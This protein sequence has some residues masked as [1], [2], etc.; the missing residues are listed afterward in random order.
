MLSEVLLEWQRSGDYFSYQGHRVF[1]KREG[2]GD[3]LLLLHGFPS[4]SI[5]W[6]GIWPL[7][8]PNFDLIAPDMMGYGFSDKS[9]SFGYSIAKQADVIVHLVEQLK[10]P[11]VHILGHDYGDTV[12]QE[13][14]ARHIEGSLSFEIKSVSLLNGGLFPETHKPLLIQK[15][16]MSPIGSILAKLMSKKKFTDSLQRICSDGLTLSDIDELWTLL[17]YKQGRLVVPQLIYY[18]QER[19]EFRERWVG[20][21]QQSDAVAMPLHLIDGVIDPISGQ[22]LVNRFRKLVPGAKVTELEEIGHYPQ[23][24]APQKVVSAFLEGLSDRFKIEQSA[25]EV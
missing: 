25:L 18:M 2:A 16:L 13:L 9:T 23:V 17:E 12:S 21:L 8:T 7:L 6:K 11:A 19:R 4:A 5:D 3:P 22:H 15:L 14:L 20:A 10:L 24:E 1:Y